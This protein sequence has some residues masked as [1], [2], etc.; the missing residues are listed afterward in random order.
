MSRLS[1]FILIFIILTACSGLK[2]A[3]QPAAQAPTLALLHATVIDGTGVEPIPDAAVL[4]MGDTILS[5]GPADQV[6]IPAG[7]ETF[8]LTGMTLLPGFINA[9]VHRGYNK[10]NLKA[11]A[12]GGVTTVRDEGASSGQVAGLKAFQAEIDAD[13]HYASLVSAGV[14]MAVPGGYGDLYVNSPE[15]ARQAVLEEIANGANA[16]KVAM[17][18]GYAGT[19]GLPKLTPEELKAIVTTTHEKGLPVSAHITQG[20]Y[21]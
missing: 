11:W 21:I 10:D 16:I 12:E 7:V 6:I 15:E 2:P 17:E 8:D 20:M 1:A 14:M 18:D 19:T 9:H 3:S 13:P 4:L 5:V